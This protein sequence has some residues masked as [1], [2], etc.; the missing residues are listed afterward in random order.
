M[1]T[2]SFQFFDE[3]NDFL[4]ENRKGI[5]FEVAIKGHETVKHMIESFGIPHTEVDLILVNENSV[6]F[7]QNLSSN[8]F[9]QV[10]PN[11]DWKVGQGVIALKPNPAEEIRFVLDCHLGKLAT[12]MRLLGFDSL[13]QKDY[14]DLELANISAKED[15][16]LLTRDRGLLMRS[17]VVRGCYI[18]KKSPKLQLIEVISRLGIAKEANPF[19]RCARC[20]GVLVSVSKDEVL[21]RLES[22]TKLYYNNFQQCAECGQIY[23]KGSHFNKLEKLVS[24]VL[25]E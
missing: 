24:D 19:S 5:Q 17:I 25:E 7:D 4:P 2:V 21:D 3:L 22:K 23:W 6:P 14:S 12:Y 13:Y 16:I 9:V 10:H 8:D 18:R 1:K 15:R 11:H 20:N